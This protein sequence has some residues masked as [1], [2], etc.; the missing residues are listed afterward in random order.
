MWGIFSPPVVCVVGRFVCLCL[1]SALLVA[2][3]LDVLVVLV[4]LVGC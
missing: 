2:D 3:V 4:V 1:Y